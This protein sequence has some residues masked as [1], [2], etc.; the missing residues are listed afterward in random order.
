MLFIVAKAH[1]LENVCRKKYVQ[2]FCP[3]KVSSA[4]YWWQNKTLVCLFNEEIIRHVKLYEMY[5][6]S[7][8]SYKRS[9]KIDQDR[10]GDVVHTTTRDQASKNEQKTSLHSLKKLKTIN[11][12][13]MRENPLQRDTS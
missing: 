1:G 10:P 4:V 12:T 9:V 8:M 7:F 2:D 13:K 3:S 11:S 5:F 6:R